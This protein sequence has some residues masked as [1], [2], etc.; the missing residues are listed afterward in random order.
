MGKPDLA[1]ARFLAELVLYDMRSELY[2][3]DLE[4]MG[5]LGERWMDGVRGVIEALGEADSGD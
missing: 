1:R 3:D 4:A 5:V 2:P